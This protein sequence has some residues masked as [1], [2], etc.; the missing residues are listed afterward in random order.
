MSSLRMFAGFCRSYTACAHRNGL[1]DRLAGAATFW[2]A[3]TSSSKSPGCPMTW[4]P[5]AESM[6]AL[7]SSSTPVIPMPKVKRPIDLVSHVWPGS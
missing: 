7:S 1:H 6:L 4:E 3:I 5:T 2:H